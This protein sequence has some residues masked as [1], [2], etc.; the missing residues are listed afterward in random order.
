MK[1][2]FIT[3][4]AMMVLPVLTFAQS[5]DEIISKHVA[6]IGGADKI[7][8]VK[9]MQYD[10][11]MSVQGMELTSKTVYIVGKSV[12]NDVSVM[13][14]QI[15]NVIDG[16]KGWIINPMQGG[17]AQDLP[18]DA[19][20]SAKSATEPSIFHLAYLKDNKFPYELTGKEKYKGKD[21]F[22]LKVSRPEG[23]FNYYI[24]ATTYQLLGSKGSVSTQGRQVETTSTYSDY[25]VV[26][27]I[28]V[29]YVS[30]VT[31]PSLPGAITA[32]LA[33]VT[34][35]QTVDPAIFVKPN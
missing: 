11:T 28:S 16:D 15:T 33:N 13:G 34:F 31:M 5:A 20:K 22:A 9:T 2:Q 8:A 12:R 32:K 18:V 25:K 7:A 3:L 19:L 29:P 14:Q 4:L 24:D 10:Q 26:D 23:I 35:N 30:E 21:A 27:G 6:A 1:N 17:N